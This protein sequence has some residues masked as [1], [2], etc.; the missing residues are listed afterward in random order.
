MTEIKL[1]IKN[2]K[3]IKGVEELIKNLN[4]IK[5]VTAK[6]KVKKNEDKRLQDRN[7]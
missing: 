5:G 3:N 7:T 6:I 1:K 4:S 2:L